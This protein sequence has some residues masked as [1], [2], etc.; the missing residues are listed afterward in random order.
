[1]SNRRL[2]VLLAIFLFSFAC[3]NNE[4]PPSTTNNS[5]S[6]VAS[7]INSTNFSEIPANLPGEQAKA[8]QQTITTASGLKYIDIVEGAGAEAKTDKLIRVNYSGWLNNGV[9]FDSSIGPGREPFTFGLGS[10][11]VI[12]GW[13]EGIVGMKVKGKR[14]L[15]IP[16]S[17]GYGPQGSLPA[18][19]PNAILIFDVEL[20]D[21]K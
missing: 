10:G 11:Q 3:E 8:G 1:M 4:N 7:P 14:K 18:I 5:P 13:D 12:A 2:I 17:Q 9:L 15:I 21:V 19:P 16:S 6:P 20:L